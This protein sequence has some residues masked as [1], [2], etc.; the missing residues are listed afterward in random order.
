MINLFL[1]R[2]E[3][4]HEKNEDGLLSLVFLFIKCW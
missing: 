3:V 4:G 2:G 1:L